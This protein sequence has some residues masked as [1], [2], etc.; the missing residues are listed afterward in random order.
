MTPPGYVFQDS[1]PSPSIMQP[2]D[3]IPKVTNIAHES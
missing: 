1:K 2:A 3:K